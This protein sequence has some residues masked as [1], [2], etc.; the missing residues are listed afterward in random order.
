MSNRR[1]ERNSADVPPS[2]TAARHKCECTSTPLS[3]FQDD[4]LSWFP[5]THL[6]GGVARVD[7]D[8]ERLRLFAEP[9]HH[10]PE[11]DHVVP[12]VVQWQ[13]C[14]KCVLHIAIDSAIFALDRA[15]IECANRSSPHRHT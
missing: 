9:T 13:P 8:A 11:A 1:E 15:Q 6:A 3:E 12:V 7:L 5:R 14:D 2:Q 4:P 10:V